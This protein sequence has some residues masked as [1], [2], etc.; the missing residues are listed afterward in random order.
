MLARLMRG[1]VIYAVGN[2]AVD[3]DISLCRTYFYL[4]AA[5]ARI[6]CFCRNTDRTFITGVQ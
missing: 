1:I 5:C 6:I 2:Y 3:A 4:S